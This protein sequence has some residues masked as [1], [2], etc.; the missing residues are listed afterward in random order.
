MAIAVAV[1]DL[2]A[3]VPCLPAIERRPDP[4]G[5]RCIIGDAQFPVLVYL[6]GNAGDCRVE[7]G[8]RCIIDRHQNRNFRRGRGLAEALP[9]GRLPVWPVVTGPD[10][11]LIGRRMVGVGKI[12]PGGL[13]RDTGPDRLPSGLKQS[14]ESW[15]DVAEIGA[16]AQDPG[17]EYA[18]AR[19]RHAECV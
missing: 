8:A 9:D 11:A 4:V 16:A 7:N 19:L 10:P 5:R 2:D 3:R 14:F 12:P 17:R 1:N 13:E 6:P 15:L 18:I